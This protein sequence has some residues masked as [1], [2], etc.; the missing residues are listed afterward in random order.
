MEICPICEGRVMLVRKRARLRMENRPV[1]IDDEFYHCEMCGEDLLTPKM[2]E[3]SL[4]RAVDVIREREG[5]LSPDEIR[6]IR[7]QYGL[8][9]PALERLIGSGAK[10]ITRWESG[11]VAPTATANTL[12]CVLRDHP[13][14][15]RSL[16][17]QRGVKLA[18][19]A[20]PARRARTGR[21]ENPGRSAA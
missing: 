21:T 1:E 12:L 6:A 9:Q 15:M 10:T 4:R 11:Q 19:E 7:K 18:S 16:A 20:A 8:S 17:A 14:V 13:E 3:A 5:L 2:A